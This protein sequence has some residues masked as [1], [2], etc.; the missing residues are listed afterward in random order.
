MDRKYEIIDVTPKGDVSFVGNVNT[1]LEALSPLGAISNTIGKI[2]ACRVQIRALQN[3]ADAI[4]RD[5][6]AR[7]KVIDGSL[8]YAMTQ[9][10]NQ[11][12]GMENYFQHAAKQLELSRIYSSERI[13]VI[14]AMTAVMTN[15][16]VP[17]QEKQLAQETIKAMSSDLIISQEAGST[18]L[19]ALIE[20]SNRNLLSVPSLAGL[21]SSK[22]NH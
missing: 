4:R 15:P 8:R 1:F 19:S 10:E 6:E 2:I 18:T 17:F 20:A 11:R 16:N 22:P 12:I 14:R 13:K 5:Y 3:E 21:L 9:L 7:N